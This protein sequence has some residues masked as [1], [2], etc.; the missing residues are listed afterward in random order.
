ASLL[1]GRMPDDVEAAFAGTGRGLLPSSPAEVR[2]SCTC[3]EEPFPCRHLVALHRHVAE[4]LDLDPFLMF[5][6]RG[7]D[8]ETLLREL[9]RRRA[10]S[11]V[12]SPQ[13][14]RAAPTVRLTP[15]PDVKPEHFYRPLL[16]L[17][18]VL[19]PYT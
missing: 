4:R 1:S 9:R 19:S 13:R 3:G 10:V 7:I 17:A 15:L 11:A 12:R 18:A 14:E 6:L 2:Q 16:P 8:R 5:L